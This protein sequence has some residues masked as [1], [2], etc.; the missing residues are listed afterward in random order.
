MPWLYIRDL[1]KLSRVNKEFHKALVESDEGKKLWI[2]VAARIVSLPDRGFHSKEVTEDLQQYLMVKPADEA[3]VDQS[4]LYLKM[5]AEFFT[6]LRCL[7]CP[8]TSN[9]ECTRT[10]VLLG[11]VSSPDRMFLSRDGSRIIF[12]SDKDELINI[13]ASCPSRKGPDFYDMLKP[14]EPRNKDEGQEKNDYETALELMPNLLT[15]HPGFPSMHPKQYRHFVVHGGV[16]AIAEF[17]TGVCGSPSADNDRGGVY[18]FS[19]H[20]GRMLRHMDV[21]G[22]MWSPKRFFMQCA[23]KQIWIYNSEHL[24]RYCYKEMSPESNVPRLAL[25]TELV[26]PALWLAGSGDA[27]G[28]IALMEQILMDFHGAPSFNRMIMEIPGLALNSCSLSSH[29]SMLHYAAMEGHVKACEELLKQ[30]ADWELRDVNHDLPLHLAIRAGHHQVI[31]LLLSKFERFD[32][33]VI[34]A[35]FRALDFPI[36]NNRAINEASILTESRETMPMLFRALV[37]RVGKIQVAK[38]RSLLFLEALKIPR[39]LASKDAVDIIFQDGGSIL[40]DFYL[41]RGWVKQIFMLHDYK[42]QEIETTRTL[43]Y[44][45]KTLGYP[46]N[47]AGFSMSW[48][49]PP[50]IYAVKIGGLETVRFLIEELGADV[51]VVS[52]EKGRS[53]FELAYDRVMTLG[54]PRSVYEGRKIRHYIRSLVHAQLPVP[55]RD[56]SPPP[57]IV[58]EWE[59]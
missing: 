34:V 59:I 56:V 26:D 5:K 8:W 22:Y 51:R 57:A 45:Y 44:F 12:Q 3:S 9:I 13:Q 21:Y 23:P 49:D 38:N 46:L 48:A 42:V 37:F 31:E 43:K 36:L 28:A 2:T 16:V 54:N 35:C 27:T 6:Q 4:I 58:D 10:E 39:V 17:F 19:C 25:V 29:R 30:G 52:R 24:H 50:L 40:K 15:L 33:R 1:N 53:I 32:E 47:E 20:D 11:E 41:E 55:R 18:F 7:V 14:S